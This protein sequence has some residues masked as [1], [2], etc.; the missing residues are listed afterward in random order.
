MA[1]IGSIM[2]AARSLVP[3]A[4]QVLPAPSGLSSSQFAAT[5]T[6]TAGSYLI[7]V[8]FFTASSSTALW[9]ETT[10]LSLSAVTVDGTHGLQ[11]TGTLP[12]GAQKIRVYYGITTINQYQDFTALPAQ[13][14]TSG[15]AGTPPTTNRAYL[16]DSDGGFVGAQSMYQWLNEGL[17]KATDLSGGILDVSG[18]RSLNG[19]STYT[20]LNNWIKLTDIYFDGF[21]VYGGNRRQVFRR[22]PNA[23]I[24]GI[25]V[26]VTLTPVTIIEMYPQ[27]NR[28]AA[29]LTLSGGITAV[30]TSLTFTVSSGSLLTN[31]GLA[32]LGSNTTTPEVVAYSANASGTTLSNL[33][34]GLGG[35]QPQAS[36]NG[37]QI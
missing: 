35:P 10:A 15:I 21:L 1:D 22:S 18:V 11:V 24:T 14:S 29:I 23:S 19:A 20:C 31:M 4:A 25:T 7:S 28:T 3:D 17:D 36:P 16:P 34:R 27:P 5:P 26:R 13:V 30:A 8:T 33:V 9:G 37:T 2:L 12:V 32:L 6:L